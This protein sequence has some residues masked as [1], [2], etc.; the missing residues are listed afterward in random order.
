MKT[1]VFQSPERRRRA[2]SSGLAVIPTTAPVRKARLDESGSTRLA[3]GVAHAP[4]EVDENPRRPIA[5][6]VRLDPG[7]GNGER[8]RRDRMCPPLHIHLEDELVVSGLHVERIERGAD[9]G[10]TLDRHLGGSLAPG[11]K[12]LVR[13]DELEQRR[14]RR[15]DVAGVRDVAREDER[16]A[17]DGRAGAGRDRPDEGVGRRHRECSRGRAER[18]PRPVEEAALEDVSPRRRAADRPWRRGA[19]RRARAERRD[20][21]RSQSDQLAIRTPHRGHDRQRGIAGVRGQVRDRGLQIRLDVGLVGGRRQRLEQQP[22]HL[23]RPSRDVVVLAELAD[24]RTGVGHDLDFT[25]PGRAEHVPVDRDEGCRPRGERGDGHRPDNRRGHG[26][27]G[28][29]LRGSRQRAARVLD[30][31]IDLPRRARDGPRRRQAGHEV[32]KRRAHGEARGGLAHVAAALHHRHELVGTSGDGVERQRQF[33]DPQGRSRPGSSL[34]DR[35]PR[36]ADSPAPRRR[37]KP[38]PGRSCRPP[39]SR[40]GRFARRER[41]RSR[42]RMR[43][44]PRRGACRSPAGRSRRPG[45]ADPRSRIRRASHAWPRGRCRDRG[46]ASSRRRA[47]SV[48]RGRERTRVA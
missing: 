28:H 26:V 19:G 22:R 2:N 30:R 32:G 5:F 23:E 35:Q 12:R 7:S 6:D 3:C 40:R 15:G 14:P 16:L 47:G 39:G 48:P 27:A 4:S 42:R 34:P 43:G 17:R 33:H 29:D 31:H 11:R 18:G 45:D 41:R 44:C 10:R 24:A 21:S 38:P 13:G 9:V 37:P 46:P 8:R 1:S 25:A 36:G 20:R